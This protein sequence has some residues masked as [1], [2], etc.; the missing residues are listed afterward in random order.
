MENVLK[1]SFYLP[2]ANK[3][4]MISLNLVKIDSYVSKSSNF[5]KMIKEV[6]T[7]WN[8]EN[9][10]GFISLK[11]WFLKCSNSWIKM[12][13]ED[14]DGKFQKISRY[15]RYGVNDKMNEIFSIGAN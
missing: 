1:K 12:V 15:E 4:F 11:K 6:K 8:D 2:C 3:L 10:C 13:K 7:K 14:D 5:W 9:D